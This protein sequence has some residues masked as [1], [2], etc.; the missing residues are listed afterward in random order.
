MNWLIHIFIT[1]FGLSVFAQ[2][3]LGVLSVEEVLLRPYFLLQEPQS[4]EFFLGDSSV[5]FGWKKSHTL[6][7]IF[8]IGSQSLLN[9]SAR[10][11]DTVDDRLGVIEAFGQVTGDYGRLRVGLVPLE[12]GVEGGWLESE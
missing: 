7:A 3:K 12:Y 11:S 8:R 5:V 1:L 6:G 9:S 10:F 4:G 2:E